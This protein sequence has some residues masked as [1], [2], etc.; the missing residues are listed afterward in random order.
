MEGQQLVQVLQASKMKGAE[1]LDRRRCSNDR[2]LFF[3][4]LPLEAALPSSLSVMTER[5][6][7]ARGAQMCSSEVIKRRHPFRSTDEFIF[8]F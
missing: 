7:T 6:P 8:I 2:A 1:G 4:R 5:L 3:L